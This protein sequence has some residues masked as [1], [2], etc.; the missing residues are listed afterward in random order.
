MHLV[1][2][3][4]LQPL[5][6][7]FEEDGTDLSGGEAQKVAIARAIYKDAE[8]M[9]LDE[10][11]SALDPYA[12]YEIYKKFSEITS[13][14]TVFSISH[15]LSSCRMCD[16]II[17]MDQGK[18]IQYGSHADLLEEKEKK[19]YQMWMAQAQYYMK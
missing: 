10:P 3:L 11:T 5:F 6:H 1:W 19:Y 12:E 4:I 9:I 15:R 14:K 8:L 18:I 16:K 2:Q 17:V 7:Y 13:N